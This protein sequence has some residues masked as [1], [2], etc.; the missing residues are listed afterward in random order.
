MCELLL[1]RLSTPA[2]GQKSGRNQYKGSRSTLTRLV[3]LVLTF[4]Q[5]HS[6]DFVRDSVAGEQN[7]DRS[8]WLRQKIQVHL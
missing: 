7:V 6:L 2:K 8:A 3:T 1:F 5:S 4:P